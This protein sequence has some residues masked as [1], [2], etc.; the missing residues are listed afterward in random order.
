M[1]DCIFCQIIAGE[2]PSFKIY[3]DETV[4]AFLDIQPVS[5]GHLLVLPKTHSENLAGLAEAE[6]APLFSLA[7]RLG[8]VA[9]NITG[10]EGFNLIVNKGSAAGQMV[11]HTHVH[12]IPR[13]AGDG[14]RHWPKIEVSTEEMKTIAQDI[15]SGLF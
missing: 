1:S 13:S 9:Q 5:R 8:Q 2:I 4:L 7:R 3:E 10:A 15:A 12:V 11:F 14:L 6:I